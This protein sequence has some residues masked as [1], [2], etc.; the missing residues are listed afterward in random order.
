MGFSND[1]WTGSEGGKQSP[2]AVQHKQKHQAQLFQRGEDLTFIARWCL[3]GNMA[4]SGVQSQSSLPPVSQMVSLEAKKKQSSG[5]RSPRGD[6]SR[7][8]PSFP[9]FLSLIL[10]LLS[11]LTLDIS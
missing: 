11:F 5:Q 7:L 9:F 1:P 2:R 10:F 4:L 3:S 8:G 6:Q